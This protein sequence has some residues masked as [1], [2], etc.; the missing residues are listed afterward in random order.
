MLVQQ[1]AVQ[2]LHE[3]IA[4]RAA[5][6]RSPMYDPFELQKQF[7]R[8]P[9]RATAKFPTIVRKDRFDPGGLLLEKGQHVFI[10]DMHRTLALLGLE[11][12]PH[13]N[14]FVIKDR[15]GKHTIK[16]SRLDR[17]LAK[18]GLEKR[19]GPFQPSC[20]AADNIPSQERYKAKP[21]HHDS[22]CGSLF[23]EYQAGLTRRKAALAAFEKQQQVRRDEITEAWERKCREIADMALTKRDRFTLLKLSRQHEAQA[24]RM[25]FREVATLKKIVNEAVPYISWSTFLRGQAAASIVSTTQPGLSI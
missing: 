7:V 9:I 25:V 10:E 17:S 3:A 12:K 16:A 6:L 23:A 18:G 8:M 20:V 1:G 15:H 11:I 22:E 4:L 13:G 24:R 5:D 14:G 21:L 19:F 2:P